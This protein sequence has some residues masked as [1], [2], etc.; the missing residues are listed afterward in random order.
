[1]NFKRQGN[2]AY[3]AR[4]SNGSNHT[5]NNSAHVT[6]NRG[7]ILYFERRRNVTKANEKNDDLKYW[8]LFCNATYKKYG[9]LI[10]AMYRS[11]S[12]SESDFCDIFEQTIRKS[13]I[14][15]VIF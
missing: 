11:C 2:M 10:G 15:T 1:M 13:V 12:Y 7:F 3:T 5:N 14:T 9:I 8:M 4:S 6:Q